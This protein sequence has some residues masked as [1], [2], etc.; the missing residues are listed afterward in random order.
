MSVIYN[1]RLVQVVIFKQNNSFVLYKHVLNNKVF[2]QILVLSSLSKT[3]EQ[4]HPFVL[5][6]RKFTL[7]SGTHLYLFSPYYFCTWKQA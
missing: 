3:I 6:L 1:V 4:G 2:R 7:I 5:K